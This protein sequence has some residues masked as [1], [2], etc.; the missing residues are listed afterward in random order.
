MT[1]GI[2]CDYFYRVLKIINASNMTYKLLETEP[3]D[4]QHDL[5]MLVCERLKRLFDTELIKQ[6]AYWS[7]FLIM[8]IMRKSPNFAFG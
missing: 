1:I 2:L 7:E 5:V 8:F 6:L 4:S 3:E